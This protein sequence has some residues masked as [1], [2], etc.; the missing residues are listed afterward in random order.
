MVNLVLIFADIEYVGKKNQNGHENG[1]LKIRPKNKK[2]LFNVLFC[3]T[4]T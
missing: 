2:G 1:L 3:H 4:K